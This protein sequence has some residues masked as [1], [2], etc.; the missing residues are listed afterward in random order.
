M[1][2]TEPY[3]LDRQLAAGFDIFQVRTD[4]EDESGFRTDSRGIGL[5]TGFPLTEYSSLGLRYTFRQDDIEVSDFLCTSGI[6]SVRVCDQRGKRTTSVVGYTWTIDRR[7][8]PIEPTR[9]WEATFSQ[10][11]AGVGGSVRYIRSEAG[12]G[13][14]YGIFED[15]VA[16]LTVT[17]GYILGWGGRD[18]R[19]NDRFYKGGGSFRG[20]EV[21]GIGPRDLSDR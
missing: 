10:D 2:F 3:F 11:F 6:I 7:D 20:F 13:V 21:S 15:V 16:S 18:V 14:Y 17:G 19:L 8:D 5:R 4:F 9:G 12:G 1:R